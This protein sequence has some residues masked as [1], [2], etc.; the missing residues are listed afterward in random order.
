MPVPVS[1]VVA[2][3]DV[4]AGDTQFAVRGQSSAVAIGK[5]VNDELDD[6]LRAVGLGNCGIDMSLKAKASTI[7][8]AARNRCDTVQPDECRSLSDDCHLVRKRGAG[9]FGCDRGGNFICIVRAGVHN[10]TNVRIGDVG[11][12]ESARRNK[13]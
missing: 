13:G 5:I 2:P 1:A 7:H 3:G 11:L 9:R 12:R 10:C 6:D 8:R 4:A